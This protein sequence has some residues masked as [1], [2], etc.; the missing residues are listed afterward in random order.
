MSTSKKNALSLKV[1]VEI[2]KEVEQAKTHGAKTVI[3]TKYKI[4]KSTLSTII[5]NKDK[6]YE[7]FE[8]SLCVPSKK[9]IR[10][11]AHQDIEEALVLWLKFACSRQVPVSGPLLQTKSGRVGFGAG[12]S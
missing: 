6:I 10:T 1:K 9:R 3:A 2:L 4:P 7:A 12:A 8:Q 11:A 5:E